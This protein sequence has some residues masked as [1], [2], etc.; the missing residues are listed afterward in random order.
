MATTGTHT[1]IYP[2]KDLTAAKA[3]FGALLGVEPFV[4]S[5]YYVGYKIGDLQAGLDPNGHAEGARAY[6]DVEDVPATFQ[7]L[8]DAG[9]EPVEHPKDVGG[10]GLVASVRDTNGNLIGL[11]GAAAS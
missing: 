8:L 6:W 3:L 11:I 10:G 9:C 7:Q 1:I 5:P 4:E 2:A